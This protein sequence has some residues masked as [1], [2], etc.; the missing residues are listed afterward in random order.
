MRVFERRMWDYLEGK[1]K[2]IVR[3]N[4]FG[5]MLEGFKYG[6]NNKDMIGF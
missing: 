2:G 4:E 5:T 6:G 1:T 3:K